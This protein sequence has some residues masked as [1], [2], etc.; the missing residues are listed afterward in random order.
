[1][2]TFSIILLSTVILNIDVAY[3]LTKI[4]ENR[5]TN[6]YMFLFCLYIETNHILKMAST[7]EQ[8]DVFTK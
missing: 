5:H 6:N 1:M 3:G 7:H 2:S 8:I 4:S